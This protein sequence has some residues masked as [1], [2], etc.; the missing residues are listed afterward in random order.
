MTTDPSL[1]TTMLAG[2]LHFPSL[3]FAVEQVPVPTPGAGE[4]LVQIKAAGVCLSD[5]HMVDG[6]MQVD[7]AG[8][9]AVTLGH[10]SAGV[11]VAVGPGV[12]QK[13]IGARVLLQ[14]QQSCGRC[15]AC[16]RDRPCPVPRTRGVDLDGGWAQYA[17]VRVDM[18]VPL[19]D[20][21]PFEQA[22]IIPDA[23][24]TPYAAVVDTAGLRPGQAVGV[25]GVGGL[26]AH[27]VRICR[28]VGAHPIVG[29]D[30]LPGAR[31]RALAFGADVA[32]DP[33]DPGTVQALWEV[34]EGRGLDVALDLAGLASVRA[35]AAGALGLGGVLV[36]VGMTAG[37]LTVPDSVMFTAKR[38]QVRGHVGSDG[39]HLEQLVRLAGSGRLD[40]APSVSELVPLAEAAEAIHRLESKVGDPVRIVL[41]P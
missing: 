1:P 13:K 36:L 7:H 38:N 4:V 31:D 29:L 20:H 9:E 23:V 25:W 3:T 27:A 5:V 6:S 12:P 28:M 35:Q 17:S 22:A 32:L 2:R 40:L 19:P 33:T 24:S 41:V 15:P 11:V 16:R 39:A 10:E 34:T 14:A 37:D 21:L 8:R 26:G 30:P 18:V